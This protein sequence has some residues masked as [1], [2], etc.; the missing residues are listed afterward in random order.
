MSPSLDATQGEI[1]G[2][3]HTGSRAGLT[4]RFK[5]QTRNGFTHI[6]QA[7]V[8][9]ALVLLSDTLGG[10]NLDVLITSLPPATWG[11]VERLSPA[12]QIPRQPSRAQ[13]WQVH[14][15]RQEL[16]TT[17]SRE[18]EAESKDQSRDQHTVS[19]QVPEPTTRTC[20]CRRQQVLIPPEKAQILP[21]NLPFV[22]KWK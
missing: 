4:L 22:K 3:L 5:W 8:P 7:S 13:S 15:K 19:R 21:H 6:W 14:G 1:Q 16:R 12:L 20:P 18:V 9:S 2:H 11:F 17:Y 10:I